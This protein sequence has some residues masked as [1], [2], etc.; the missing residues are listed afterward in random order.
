MKKSRLTLTLAKPH[1]RYIVAE[2]GLGPSSVPLCIT[3]PSFREEEG[4]GALLGN[5]IS[6]CGAQAAYPEAYT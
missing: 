4:L 3:M 6:L 1:G 5:A 2:M